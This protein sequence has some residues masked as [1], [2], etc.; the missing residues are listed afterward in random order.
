MVG[1]KVDQTGTISQYDRNHA[2]GEIINMRNNFLC[3]LH[4]FFFLLDSFYHPFEKDLLLSNYILL[5]QKLCISWIYNFHPC[6]E[7][8]GRTERGTGTGNTRA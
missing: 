4:N 7:P 6:S 5:K 3:T 2:E 1:M 8:S